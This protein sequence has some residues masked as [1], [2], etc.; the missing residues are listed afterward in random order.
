MSGELY[1]VEQAAEALQLHAKTVLRMIREGRLKAAK[2]GKSYRIQKSDIDA[3]AGVVRAEARQSPDR[4]TVIADYGDLSPDVAMKLANVMGAM[5]NNREA[6]AEP[7]RVD[8]A[9]DPHLRR[10]KVVIAGS[11]ADAIALLQMASTVLESWR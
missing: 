8:T 11:P 5:L 6:P 1:T 2:I 4:V 10:M 7:R 3:F 9:Y